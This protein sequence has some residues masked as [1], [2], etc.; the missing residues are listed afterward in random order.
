MDIRKEQT[1]KA[2]K[3]YPKGTR[4]ISPISG[5]KYTSKG[6][7]DMSNYLIMK[8]LKLKLKNR[9]VQFMCMLMKNGHKL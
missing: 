7:F 9:P 3:K 1:S 4:F 6:V 8:M 2:R 5:K